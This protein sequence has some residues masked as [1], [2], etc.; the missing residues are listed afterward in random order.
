MF[1]AVTP[2]TNTHRNLRG[3]ILYYI[4][5]LIVSIDAWQFLMHSHCLNSYTAHLDP[6]LNA[7]WGSRV[8]VVVDLH[9][10]EVPN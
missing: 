8:P 2:W 5:S 10:F 1:G 7:S 9:L 6:L 4:L 3:A